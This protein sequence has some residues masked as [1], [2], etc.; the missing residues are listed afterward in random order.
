MIYDIDLLVVIFKACEKA[1]NN[2]DKEHEVK[3]I[4]N[5]DPFL[6]FHL[7]KSQSIRND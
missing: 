6:K 1:N 7:Y 2:V 5:N 4:V 3:K